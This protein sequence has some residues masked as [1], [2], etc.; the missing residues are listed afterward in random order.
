MARCDVNRGGDASTARDVR[1]AKKDILNHIDDARAP[2]GAFEP[3]TDVLLYLLSITYGAS[4]ARAR[5]VDVHT[6]LRDS[7]GR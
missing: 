5:A 7:C 6:H 1:C 4:D 2:F 3:F